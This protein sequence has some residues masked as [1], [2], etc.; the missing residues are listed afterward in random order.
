MKKFLTLGVAALIAASAMVSTADA[1]AKKVQLIPSCAAGQVPLIFVGAALGLLTG[2]F[3]AVVAYGAPYFIG[4][5]LIGTAA[6]SA[7][8]VVHGNLTGQQCL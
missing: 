8:G 5:T 3:G 4:G 2:G 7:V 1:S 6:G